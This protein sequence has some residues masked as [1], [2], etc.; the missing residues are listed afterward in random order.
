MLWSRSLLSISHRVVAFVSKSEF[1][2]IRMEVSVQCPRGTDIWV[3][4][5]CWKRQPLEAWQDLP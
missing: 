1:D 5:R 4:R 2:S 3:G